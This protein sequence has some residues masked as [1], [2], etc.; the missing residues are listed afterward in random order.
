MGC[1]GE[2]S[3][4]Y[5]KQWA[6]WN[7]GGELAE[8]RFSSGRNSSQEFGAGTGD[9]P[10]CRPADE[11]NNIEQETQPA[12]AGSSVDLGHLRLWLIHFDIG[13]AVRSASF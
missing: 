3:S 6:P 5:L 9:R 10:A 11:H 1:I 2:R 12:Q 4:V 7:P 8:I 13:E